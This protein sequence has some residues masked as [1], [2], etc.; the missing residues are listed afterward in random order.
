[1]GL[2]SM[3]TATTSNRSVWSVQDAEPG[4]GQPVQPGQTVDA[5]VRP[6]SR[7][8]GAHAPAAGGLAQAALPYVDASAAEAVQVFV[9]NPRGWALTD[10]DPRQ[11]EAFLA[12]CANGRCPSYIH[13]SLLVNLGSPT[14]GHGRAVRPKPSRTGCAA[15]RRSARA[16]WFSTPA[17]R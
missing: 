6:L 16:A 10:G 2:R 15:A 3:S 4:A 1:M 9:S 13:A 17:P 11:D 12:G 8:V 5:A 7:P 14:A